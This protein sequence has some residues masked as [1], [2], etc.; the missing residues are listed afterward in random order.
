MIYRMAQKYVQ[1]TKYILI[2]EE[3]K[4][5]YLRHP[6]HGH[7]LQTGIKSNQRAY[8][9]IAINV[10]EQDSLFTFALHDMF[11]L[12][13]SKKGEGGRGGEKGQ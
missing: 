13:V 4:V 2:Q 10:V 8:P 5:R 6:I 12:C 1:Y 9:S 3:K 7:L 11:D